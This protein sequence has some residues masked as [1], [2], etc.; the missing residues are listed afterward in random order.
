VRL[1]GLAVV[2]A[3][4]ITLAPLAAETQQAGKQYRIG[5]LWPASSTS[6]AP[7]R[8]ALQERLGE[9]GYVHGKNALTEARWADGRIE[10]LPVLATELVGLNVDLIIAPGEAAIRAAKEAT[11][12]IPVLMAPSGD[13]VGTGLVAS[14][15]RPGG[16]ITG[17]TTQSA[18]LTAKRLELIKET[19]PKVSRLAVLWNAVA[20]D[21]AREWSE[22]ELAGRTLGLTLH[23][24]GVRGS[25]HF[26]GAFA[27]MINWRPDAFLTFADP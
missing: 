25:G 1:I 16:N 21:K 10:R 13:P 14:L 17:V 7:F 20:P 15:A 22:T 24:F 26:D 18:E 12:T 2:V 9:R 3:F 8:A 23:S 19:F 11:K 6:L 4:S 27:A 5:V